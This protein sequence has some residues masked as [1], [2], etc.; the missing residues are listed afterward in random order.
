M[1]GAR[2]AGYHHGVPTDV[3]REIVDIS[4]AIE[5]T[6]GHAHPAAMFVEEVDLPSGEREVPVVVEQIDP[7]G[8]VVQI[9]EVQQTVAVNVAR[10]QD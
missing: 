2:H 9:E 3:G 6:T 7:T 5:I 8:N 1:R 4:V 10:I